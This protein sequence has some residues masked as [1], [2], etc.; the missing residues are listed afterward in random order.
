MSEFKII[1][2]KARLHT[3]LNGIQSVVSTTTLGT[4]GGNKSRLV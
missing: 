1:S 2:G 3:P 4:I